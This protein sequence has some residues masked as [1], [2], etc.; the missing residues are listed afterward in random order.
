MPLSSVVTVD[1]SPPELVYSGIWL[2]LHIEVA[3]L[4]ELQREMQFIYGR[5]ENTFGSG[6]S[7]PKSNLS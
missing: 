4:V 6:D 5:L 7:F 2:Q 1:L 3:Q